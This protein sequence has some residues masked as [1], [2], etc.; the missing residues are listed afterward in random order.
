MAAIGGGYHEAL[1]KTLGTDYR[2]RLQEAIPVYREYW[3][4]TML[5]DVRLLA[6][7]RELL[8]DLRA[9]GARCAVLTNKHGPSARAVCTHLGLDQWL[10]GVFG[11][12]DTPW[13]KPAVEFT[14]HTL[15]RLGAL[16]SHTVLVGDSPWDIEA[17]RQAGL[18]GV[19]GVTTGTHDAAQLAAYGA[20]L[21]DIFPDLPALHRHLRAN[22][23]IS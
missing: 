18:A 2:H 21:A 15:A 3:E 9:A 4:R 13:L 7:T 23:L 12:F 8:A 17:A 5:D 6:G 14:G 1:G 22:D 10:A 16:A 20:R 19:Y 11:A